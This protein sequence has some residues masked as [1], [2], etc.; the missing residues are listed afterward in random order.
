ML[1]SDDSCSISRMAEFLD[2]TTNFEGWRAN[3]GRCKGRSVAGPAWADLTGES[4]R[5]G[6]AG[7]CSGLL[8]ASR[9]CPS[10]PHVLGP[11]QIKNQHSSFLNRQCNRR[12]LPGRIDE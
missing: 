5:D 4:A 11:L 3:L 12:P 6:G 8:R 1:I 7:R 2:L 9:P 10:W